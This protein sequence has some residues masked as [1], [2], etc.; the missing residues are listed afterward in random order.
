M[1]TVWDDLLV[2]LIFTVPFLMLQALLSARK[3][4]LWGFIIPILWTAL[5]AWV[6]IKSSESGHMSEMILFFLATDII[7][8]GILVLVRYLKRKKTG[9]NK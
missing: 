2:V 3:K 6:A 9:Q 1:P 4:L 8:F 5:G 7:L